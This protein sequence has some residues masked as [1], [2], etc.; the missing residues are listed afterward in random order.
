[1][2]QIYILLSY[3]FDNYLKTCKFLEVPSPSYNTSITL[4]VHTFLFVIFSYKYVTTSDG[5][6]V[7]YVSYMYKCMF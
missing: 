6:K 7:I 2:K 1:M 5:V 3:V 4:E